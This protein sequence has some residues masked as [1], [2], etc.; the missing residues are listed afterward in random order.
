MSVLAPVG[1]IA[2]LLLPVLFLLHLRHA[3]YRSYT[4][5]STLLWSRLL[6]EAPRMRPR[7]RP[8]YL[9]LLALQL[10]AV[11]C[12]ALALARPALNAAGW[13][14]NVV[15]A[16]DTSLAM[17]ATDLRP[18]RLARAQGTVSG[19][20][21]SLAPWDTMT[22]VDVGAAPRVLAASS[23][24][25]ALH[26]AL[27]DL[28]PGIGPSSLAVDGPLLAGLQAAG[29]THTRVLLL[30]PLGA[31]SSAL[32][33]L[34]RA[35]PTL[36]VQT[37]G[38]DGSDRGVADLSIA[39]PSNGVTASCEAFARL[40]NTGTRALATHG[41]GGGRWHIGHEGDHTSGAK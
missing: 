32:S 40:I 13:R 4:L 11:G 24:H 41:D 36:Q 37:I 16:V 34:R 27:N 28:A 39:C 31:P 14:S 26:Q 12:G 15:V 3:R 10:L 23:D 29:G 22:I 18:S 7:R 30:A 2:L 6:A 1:L 17:S 33:Q 9:L 35:V 5:S 21:D 25:D 20:I 19:M 38:V 8:I